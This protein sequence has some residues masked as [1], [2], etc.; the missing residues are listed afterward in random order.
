MA[1]KLQGK[2]DRELQNELAPFSQAQDRLANRC[3]TARLVGKAGLGLGFI[4]AIFGITDAVPVLTRTGL[5]LISL[6][7]IATIASF[8]FDINRQQRRERPPK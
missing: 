8:I 2:I 4:V 6:G 1:K 5:A 7:I 3:I